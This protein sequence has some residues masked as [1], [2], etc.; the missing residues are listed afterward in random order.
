MMQPWKME[1]DRTNLKIIKDCSYFERL[2]VSK[3]N[4]RLDNYLI[5]SKR[6]SSNNDYTDNVILEALREFDIDKN[7]YVGAA[8]IFHILLNI[9]ERVSDEKVSC[10]FRLKY[11]AQYLFILKKYLTRFQSSRPGR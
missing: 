3:R 4:D 11:L 2:D 10:L 5:G 1:E 7:N 9:G 6:Q 8:K